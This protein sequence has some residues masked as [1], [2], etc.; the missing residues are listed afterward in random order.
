MAKGLNLNVIS[1]GI[2][3]QR[4]LDYLREIDC[5]E[6]QGFLFGKPLESKVITEMLK[7]RAF[8]LPEANKPDL[9]HP[10]NQH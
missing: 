7:K 3:T 5:N 8:S 10:H 9:N 4:Q 1:E 6:A 2:E